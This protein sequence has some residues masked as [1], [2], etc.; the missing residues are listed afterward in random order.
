LT[1]LVA[2]AAVAG[3]ALRADGPLKVALYSGIYVRHDAVSNSL[4]LKLEALR[5]LAA[6]GAP[7]EITVFTH[8]SDFPAPEIRVVPSVSRLVGSEAFWSADVHIF[9]FGMHYELF[10]ALFVIP[11]DRSTLVIEHNTTPPELVDLPRV[12]AGCQLALVQRHNLRLAQHVACVSE[13]NLTMARSVGVP[14]DRLSVLHLPPAHAARLAPRTFGGADGGAR[15][16][17][18]LFVGRLVRAKGIRDLLVMAERLWAERPGQFTIDLVGSPT[19]SDPDVFAQ[20]ERSLAEHGGGAGRLR[21]HESLSEPEMADLFEASDLLVIPSY[22]EGYCVPV[23]EALSAG[24]HVVA[25]DAGNL[26]NVLGGLGQLVGTGEVGALGD[27]VAIFIDRARAAGGSGDPI[28]VPTSG[29]DQDEGTWLAA[30]REH[31][32]DYTS[33]HYETVFL[34]LFAQLARDSAKGY[35]PSLETAVGQRREEIGVTP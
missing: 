20:V 18:L 6:L 28:S 9:E 21:L 5:R 11:A 2:Q 13:F 35:S 15:P 31:L 12:R 19:F 16:V 24:C 30:V 22:H 23:I 29:G 4:H 25:Y 8:A 3:P 26:P 33:A 10:D 17:R 7:I 34:D 32:A 1:Q 27:A 14:E